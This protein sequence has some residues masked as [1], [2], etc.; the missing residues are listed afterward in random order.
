MNTTGDLEESDVLFES[1]D[2][3]MV[4]SQVYWWQDKHRPRKPKYFNRVHTE[5]E[6]KIYSHMH[7]EYDNPPS[8]I[9][10]GY[11]FSLLYLDLIDSEA[12][13]YTTEKDGESAETCI[14]RFHAGPPYEDIAFRILDKEWDCSAKKGFK[15]TF[16]KGILQRNTTGLF[17]R[18]PTFYENS[19]PWLSR[20]EGEGTGL[21]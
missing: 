17:K 6:W 8:K 12:P 1:S 11:K 15:C 20:E 16:E 13:T 18:V 10:K 9:V 14:I 19:E 5:Y 7:Y 4:E 3:V 2:E 21:L